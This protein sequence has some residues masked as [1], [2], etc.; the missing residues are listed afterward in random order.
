MSVLSGIAYLIV[1]GRR[2][3]STYLITFL[4]LKFHTH[5]F[6]LLHPKNMPHILRPIM[7]PYHRRPCVINTLLCCLAPLTHSYTI[8]N[9]CL[10][11]S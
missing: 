4:L 8:G 3:H 1:S 5:N 10:M 2:R 6:A 11:S 9:E 7:H